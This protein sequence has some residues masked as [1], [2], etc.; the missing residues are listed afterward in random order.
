MST[1]NLS[2]AT[3]LA[4]I[5]LA[6]G[7]VE[8]ATRHEDGVRPETDTDHTIMLGLVACELAPAHLDRTRIAAF[9]LVHDLVEVYAGDENTLTATPDALAAKQAREDAARERLI[10]EL[11]DGSWLAEMLTIYEAQREPEARFVRLIDKVLPK[12]TH[13]ANRCA[14]AL[15]LVDRAGFID[16]HARQLAKL[17][18]QY[19]EFLE[20]LDLLEA[21]M[22]HAEECWPVVGGAR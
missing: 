19:G 10:A 21:S 8:R 4:T 20:A 16:A 15:P 1:D 14:A 17:R 11:G 9:A 2:R 12:L 18:E 22:K 13:S 7:R 5:A 6:F 3:R